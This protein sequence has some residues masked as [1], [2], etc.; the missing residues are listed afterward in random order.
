VDVQRR[1]R[2]EVRGCVVRVEPCALAEADDERRV[3]RRGRQPRQPLVADL[4]RQVVGDRA[5]LVA[6]EGKLREHDQVGA[7]LARLVGERAGAHDVPVD[8]TEPDV[9][10]GEGETH[11]RARYL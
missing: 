10:L 6:A 1:A 5:D 11:G 9:E 8:I 2:L 3:A 7:R 4:H